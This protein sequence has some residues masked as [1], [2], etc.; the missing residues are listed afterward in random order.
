MNFAPA[1]WIPIG[2]D[3]I[4]HYATVRRLNVFAHD[5]LICK[6]ASDADHLELGIAAATYRDMLKMLELESEFRQHV[7]G[8]GVSDAARQMFELI[9]DDQRQCYVCRTTCFLSALI[10]SCF[11]KK[12]VC[13]NHA[14][15]LTCCDP[16]KLCLRYLLF[17]KDFELFFYL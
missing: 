6:I 13:Q 14:K 3:S 11:P 8:M 15:L 1:D 9:E 10:C 5:E 4:A 7:A 17:F 12:L 2:R 16:V